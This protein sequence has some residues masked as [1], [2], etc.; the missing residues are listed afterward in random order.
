MVNGFI[1][2]LDGGFELAAGQIVIAAE[3]GLEV[4]HFLLEVGDIDI[5]IT[6]LRQLPAVFHRME[7]RAPQQ[8]DDGNEEL[9]ADDIHFGVAVADIGDA[10]IQ[11]AVRLQ[12]GNQDGIFAALFLTVLIQFPE[13]ILVLFFA[14][15]GIHLVFHLEHDG[16][17][18]D[19]IGGGLPEDVIAFAAGAGV[20]VLLKV[21]VG[22]SGGPQTVEFDLTVLFQC[23]SHH[24]GGK[25]GFEVLII[26]DDLILAAELPLV[27]FPQLLLLFPA[28]GCG[29]LQLIV[30]LIDF[31]LTFDQ[32][33][34][35]L[36]G[37][38][39]DG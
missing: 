37:H 4:V 21:S 39:L 27:A 8:G 29:F 20:V 7:C 22:E 33:V 2:L 1:D 34:L 23:F 35:F 9:R 14:G 36:G 24:F 3:A 16:E 26:G 25:A 12:Q 17:K 31:P 15:G 5:L 28:G 13:E 11:L 6:D 10:A 30:Q 32:F 19:A 38:F 18:F